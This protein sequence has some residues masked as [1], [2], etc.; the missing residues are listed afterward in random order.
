MGHVFGA[1]LTLFRIVPA[2]HSGMDLLALKLYAILHVLTALAYHLA[3]CPTLVTASQ[4]V[5]E[6]HA[7]NSFLPKLVQAVDLTEIAP[8]QLDTFAAVYLV[9]REAT[10]K[11]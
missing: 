7:I 3:D 1:V 2:Q 11:S 8:M 4:I 5:R 10:A 6:L 9:F